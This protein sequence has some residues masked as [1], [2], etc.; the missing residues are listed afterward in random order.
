MA[1]SHTVHQ[2]IWE[3]HYVPKVEVRISHRADFFLR[4]HVWPWGDLF[5]PWPYLRY[6]FHL[7]DVPLVSLLTR[8]W[9]TLCID[10][11]LFTTS[12]SMK[13]TLFP[14][15]RRHFNKCLRHF[16]P[17][18]KIKVQNAYVRPHLNTAKCQ[19]AIL[20][21]LQEVPFEGDPTWVCRRFN[22]FWAHLLASSLIESNFT[23]SSS[24]FVSHL[25]W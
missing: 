25:I 12:S 14:L 3:C 23:P 17:K 13:G 22:C 8:F 9:K 18:W 1:S 24:S 16:V 6:V 19:N 4:E 7:Y 2:S 15:C 10:L 5:W 11:Q 21:V 20:Q